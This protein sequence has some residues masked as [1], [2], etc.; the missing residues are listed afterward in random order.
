[1][2]VSTRYNGVKAVEGKEIWLNSTKKITKLPDIL[3][4]S[5]LYPLPYFM[6]KDESDLK[7]IVKK[8]STV[9]IARIPDKQDSNTTSRSRRGWK[10]SDLNNWGFKFIKNEEV[11]TDL[12]LHDTGSSSLSLYKKSISVKDK[13]GNLLTFST[14]ETEESLVAIFVK[15]GNDT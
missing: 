13:K 15:K 9:Y 4:N 6:R 1:M 8:P 12:R 10:S 7:I 2:K 11:L 14:T 3:N 5:V